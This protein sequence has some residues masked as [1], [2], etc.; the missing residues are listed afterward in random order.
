MVP[1]VQEARARGVL[2]AQPPFQRLTHDAVVWADG[3]Q[4]RADAVVWCTG[5]RPALAHLA[6]LSLTR[7]NGHPVTHGTEA[8]DAPGIHLLGYG[9]WTGP[10]SAT[11]IGVGRTARDAVDKLT[12]S[13][14]LARSTAG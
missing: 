6:P 12:D 4:Q 13:A 9:D 5:F 10:A 8:V 3:R 2:H 7:E 1:S 11:L 14:Q